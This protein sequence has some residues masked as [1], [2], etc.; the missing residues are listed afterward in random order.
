MVRERTG[1]VC[2][3]SKCGFVCCHLGFYY[4]VVH[5]VEDKLLLTLS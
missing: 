2:S 3:K 1:R 5:L 4:R